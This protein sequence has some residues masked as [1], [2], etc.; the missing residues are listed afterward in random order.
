MFIMFIIPLSLANT[1]TK[2]VISS[3]KISLE[4]CIAHK[5]LWVQRG[6]IRGRSILQN[7]IDIDVSARIAA[8]RGNCPAILLWDFAAAFPS[9]SHVYLH[10]I[11][12][13]A[14]LPPKV[15]KFVKSIY[16]NCCHSIRIDGKL[17]PGPDLLGGVRQGCPLSGILFALAIDPLLRIIFATLEAEDVLRAYAD[18]IAAV[19]FNWD[20]TLPKLEPIFELFRK[21][22]GLAVNVKKTILIPLVPCY[23]EAD[24]RFKL[25]SLL[26][27][28]GDMLIKLNG[29][30]L[31]YILV[32]MVTQP[33]GMP[34]QKR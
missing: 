19:L 2:L 31:E 33:H 12:L 27:V 30:I 5:V 7:I 22:S 11:L 20:I 8:L 34:L 21:C 15:R 14:G 32:R 6:F 10:R 13:A 23:V 3:F 18:D 16:Q 9:V 25:R 24:L 26:S 1:F 17:F 28:W 4:R 29:K